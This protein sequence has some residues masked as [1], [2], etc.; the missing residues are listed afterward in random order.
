MG[1]TERH[2]EELAGAGFA[3]PA[4][5]IAGTTGCLLATAIIV[6]RETDREGESALGVA[7][8]TGFGVLTSLGSQ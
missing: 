7:Q 6:H 5:L 2:V 1:S 3:T 8:G 4:A